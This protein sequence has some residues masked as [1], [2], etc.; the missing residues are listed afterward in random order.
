M[1]SHR[2]ELPRIRNVT[3]D[4]AMLEYKIRA[5]ATLGVPGVRHPLV[6]SQSANQVKVTFSRIAKE[7]IRET[8]WFLVYH[9]KALS[10]EKV[11]ESKNRNVSLRRGNSASQQE[12][13]VKATP[14]SHAHQSANLELVSP[15]ACIL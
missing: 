5:V 4:K 15:R 2:E 14:K 3:P 6:K 12:V 13:C 10:C 7:S 8:S 11:R 9:V 1:W